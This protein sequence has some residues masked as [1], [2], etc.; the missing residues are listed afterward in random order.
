MSEC[1]CWELGVEMWLCDWCKKRMCA[2]CHE[3][4][5]REEHGVS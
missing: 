1:H 2:H 4:H 5:D 3:R